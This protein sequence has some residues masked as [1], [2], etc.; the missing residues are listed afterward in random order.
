M[1]SDSSSTASG[2]LFGLMAVTTVFLYVV[3]PWFGV[4]VSRWVFYADVAFFAVLAVVFIALPALLR[5]DEPPKQG[6][7]GS[8]LDKETEKD[9][10]NGDE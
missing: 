8:Q 3:L 6:G 2:C 7:D 5:R 9:K 1:A 10:A 4:E